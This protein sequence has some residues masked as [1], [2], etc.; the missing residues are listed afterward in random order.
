MIC[1]FLLGDK[2]YPSDYFDHES[3]KPYWVNI[4]R[5][6]KYCSLSQNEQYGFPTLGTLLWKLWPCEVIGFLGCEEINTLENWIREG[7]RQPYCRHLDSV[8]V[9]SKQSINKLRLSSIKNILVVNF[10]T[11]KPFP[12]ATMI[13]FCQSRPKKTQQTEINIQTIRNLIS[14]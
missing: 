8:Q 5:H 10:N 13:F 7:K 12:C 2:R 4:F 3:R 11:Y 1:F 9:S 6:T 14:L